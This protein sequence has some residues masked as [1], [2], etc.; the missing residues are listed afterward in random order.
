ML[1]RI[2]LHNCVKKNVYSIFIKPIYTLQNNFTSAVHSKPQ[3]LLNKQIPN[4]YTV[5]R[6]R[7]KKNKSEPIDTT[8]ED[9]NKNDDDL[10]DQIESYE[11]LHNRTVPSLRLDTVLKT[12][13]GV[14]RSKIDTDFYE[15]KIRINGNK[16][17][18]KN[19]EVHDGDE[20]D[21]FIDVSPDNP[22]FIIVSRVKIVATS[23]LQNGFKVSFVRDKAL[24]IEN[25]R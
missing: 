22:N 13:L 24:L 8:Y 18:K 1:A 2:F 15:S 25:Y 12:C 9:E 14:G 4:L 10:S 11:K 6:L 21:V 20:L 7:H 5:K 19:V 23:V 17:L 16:A 3:Y